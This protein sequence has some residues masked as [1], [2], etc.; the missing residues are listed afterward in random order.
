[1][2]LVAGFSTDLARGH[3][4]CAWH[5]LWERARWDEQH[6]DQTQALMVDEARLGIVAGGIAKVGS[7][8]P[9]RSGLPGPEST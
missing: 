4:Q 1:M 2:G 6:F 7:E 3:I 5:P 8:E 9:G